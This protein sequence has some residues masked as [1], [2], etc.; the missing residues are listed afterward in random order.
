MV[1]PLDKKLLGDLGLMKGQVLTI[2]LVV[3]AGIAAYVSLQSTFHSL[4]DS[5]DAYYERYRFG[6]VFVHVERAPESVH[7]RLEDLPGVAR[8][9]TRVLESVTLPVEG[10]VEPASGTIVSIPGGREPALNGLYLRQGRMP[11]PG[12][13]DEVL[14]LETFAEAHALEPGDTVPAVINGTLR[15]LR[16][17][18]IAMSPEF[19]FNMGPGG[20]GGDDEKF[21]VLWMDRSV[22]GPAFDMEGAFNDVVVR[23]SP[24]ASE[25]EV[26]AQVD[27]LLDPYGTLGAQGRSKQTS[28]YVLESELAQL[29]NFA[30]VIP[31]IFLGVAAFLL[32]VVLSRLVHLQRPEIATLKAVG[33]ADR[34]I[35]LHYLKL[36]SLI[37]LLGTVIGIGAGAYLGRAMT[38]L[39]S[40]YFRFPVLR[41]RV[42]VSVAVASVVVSL[43]AAFAGA[44]VAVRRIAALP[45]AEAMRP[46]PPARY[47]RTLLERI[48][49]DRFIGPV[50]RMILREIERRPLRTVLSALAIGMATGIL[51]VGRFNFD[52]VE[53]LLDVTFQRSFREDATVAFVRPMPARVVHEIENMP[54][55]LHAEGMRSVPVRARMGHRWRDAT[56]N[57]YPAGGDLRR[58]VDVYERETPLPPRGVVLT[59]KLAEILDVDVGDEVAFE[60]REGERQTVSVPVSGLIE[61]SFG[62][63]AHIR[64]DALSRLL[65]EEPTV[66]MVLMR[67]DPLEW[68]EL[69]QRLIDLPALATIFRPESLI[70]QFREQS[71]EM[72]MTMTLIIT[73]FA[74]TIAV[75]VVYNNAR[76]ALSMRSRD[77]ASL[78][79]LGFTRGE[80]STILLGE[81]AIQVLLAIPIG[82]VVGRLL[83]EA[84]MSTV[85]PEMYRLAVVIEPKTYAFAAVVTL[86]SGLLSALLV[87][88][89][90]DR[91]DLIG[92]LKTRE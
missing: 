25:A 67:I 36:V 53:H 3:A 38:D 6:D 85:D 23:L 45:P 30:T 84:V 81:L 69:E 44:L 74:A 19:I 68:Q 43:A 1:S 42:D 40:D 29:S 52:A 76:V 90:L 49:L 54:G 57:A 26:I 35:G 34:E 47:R 16:V 21:G 10:L 18:G 31:V 46:A 39:Y 2:A 79:V 48:G 78:R 64:D 51:V 83:A 65:G 20:F 61:E 5:R 58:L 22:L 33:Y 56:L 86:A 87:R 9:Y 55:V 73:L 63:N 88:R 92:V 8:V 89:K 12:R 41:Y 32:N 15:R 37:V 72:L 17:V 14:L 4:E 82:L 59:R 24:G 60:I 28:N 80:I 7:R 91:L 13:A 66:N 70:R 71:G 11:E 50:G 27:R 75:G 62:L 77:L